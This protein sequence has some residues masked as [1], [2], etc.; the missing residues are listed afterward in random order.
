MRTFIQDLRYGLR[1]LLKSPGFTV[2]AVLTLALGIGAN[3]AILSLVDRVLLHPL[4]FH[5]PDQLVRLLFSNRGVGARNVS[6]SEPELQDLRT[7]AGIFQDVSVVWS[8]SVNLTGSERPERLELLG[9]SAD[10]FSLLGAQAQLGRLFG[11]QDEAEGFAEAAVISDS[12]WRRSF[13]ADPHILGRRL[14]L[15]SDPYTV[16]GVLPPDFRH[17]GQTVS[18]DVDIF[19]TAGF[20]A[21]PFPKPQRSARFLPGAIARLKPGVTFE[22]AQ[23]KLAAFT[24]AMRSD[25]PADYP[26]RTQWTVEA[27]PLQQSLVGDVRPMLWLLMGSVILVILIASA[28]IANLLLARASG[29]QREIAVR[30][31]LGARSVRIVRQMLTEALLLALIAGAA[32]VLTAAAALHFLLRYVP[33]RIPRLSEVHIDPTVLGFALLITLVTGVLFGLAPALQAARGDMT[34]AIREGGRGSGYSVRTSR[35]RGLLIGAEIAVSVMLMVGAGLLLRTFWGLLQQDPG[36]NPTRVVTASLW[37][38]VPNNPAADPYRKPDAIRNFAREVVRRL[39]ALPGVDSAAITSDLPVTG[40]AFRRTLLPDD[41]ASDPS[42]AVAGEASAVTP[43]YFNTIQAALARG[44]V[45]SEDDDNTHPRVAIV[46]ESTAQR[47]WPNQDGLGNDALGKKVRLGVAANAP[48][49]LVVGVIKDIRADALDAERVPHVY[50]PLY[51]V[52]VRQM[53]VVLRSSLPAATLE[54][55]VRAEIQAVDPNL[56]VFAVRSMDEV[57]GASLASRRFSAQLV[58]VFAALALLLASIGIYGLLAYTVGQRSHEIGVRMALGAKPAAIRQMVLGQGA[59]LAIIGVAAGVV[60]AALAAPLLARLLYGVRAIDPLV[61]T[62][63]PVLLMVVA[64]LAS[65][66][67]AHRATK[68]DPMVALRDV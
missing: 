10:Y 61:F 11:P 29:R 31:A 35:L 21:D 51:Q 18:T 60:C 53:S 9:V 63:V 16:V 24:T 47:F 37:L 58:A 57:I 54:P 6:F 36:F 38:A 42:A 39:N 28:N 30:L 62:L 52:G 2:V 15:D 66:I 3:T 56:P 22:Q 33:A 12:L 19:A 40:S 23:S 20:R 25:Y 7:R 55:R 59:L 17:P 41:R 27:E 32:G 1:L 8:V 67:P 46:D 48:P 68:V 45:F 34:G 64:L 50:S 44:R 13:G 26:A 65:Y 14:Q 4:P 43:A 5:D 49:L